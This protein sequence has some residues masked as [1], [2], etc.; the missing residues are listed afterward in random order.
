MPCSSNQVQR[1][2]LL[3][4]HHWRALVNHLSVG[5]RLMLVCT[6]WH[7]HKLRKRHET[8]SGNCPA[9]Y[10]R[11]ICC[12]SMLH[13]SFLWAVSPHSWPRCPLERPPAP[14]HQPVTQRPMASSQSP[15]QLTR[16]AP[17]LLS[18]ARYTTTLSPLLL[19]KF[20]SAIICTFPFL[21][22][23]IL[24]A[25]TSLSLIC[26]SYSLYHLPF[27]FFLISLFSPAFLHLQ[28]FANLH[29]FILLTPV[30]PP[31]QSAEKMLV[32]MKGLTAER[33]CSIRT[34]FL[35]STYR[36]QW[37]YWIRNDIIMWHWN[38]FTISSAECIHRRGTR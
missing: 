6:H 4:F 32:K 16:L 29:F 31:D 19:P 2:F 30:V 37:A 36:R 23:F 33:V 22:S 21:F 9:V 10:Q 25:N 24:P 35:M 38:R 28:P 12:W 27:A 7:R 5:F 11:T 13:A 18:Q 17:V 3:A 15:S 14:S 20:H 8:F 1:G 26:F 34:L